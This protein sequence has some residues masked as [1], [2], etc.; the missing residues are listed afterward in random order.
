VAGEPVLRDGKP[1]GLDTRDAAGIVADSQA[2]M[3]RDS[4]KHDFLG[5]DGDV[6]SPLSLPFH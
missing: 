5:R 3:L 1:V 6:I 2:R 4:Q